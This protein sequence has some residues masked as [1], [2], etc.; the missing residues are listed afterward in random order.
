M[1]DRLFALTGRRVLVTGGT[2][3]VGRAIS[4]HFARAGA[5]V[6]ANYAH[7]EDAAASLQ[8]ETTVAGASLQLC[9]ADLTMPEG[10]QRLFDG[11][12]SAPLSAFIHCAATG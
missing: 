2:R 6:V 8:E 11:V 9:R 1:T 10:R 3:G 5:H 12:G 7:D 4:L